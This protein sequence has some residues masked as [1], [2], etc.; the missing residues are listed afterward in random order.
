MTT[1]HIAH[2]AK[3]LT[4]MPPRSPRQRLRGYAIL[5]R[6]IDKGLATLNGSAGGYHFDCPVDNRLLKFKGI[7]GD[8]VKGMLASG[9]SEDE[10]VDWFD[11]QGESRPASEV[12]AWSNAVETERPYDNP[13]LSDW[14]ADECQRLGL[15]PKKT[16]LFDYL[17]YDDRVSFSK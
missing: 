5:A 15:D 4:R 1:S 8:E 16:T 14:F 17:D 12:V 6:M 9:V 10:I 3:D 2:S 13:E 7:S 11:A